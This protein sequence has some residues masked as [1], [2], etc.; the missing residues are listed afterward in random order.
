MNT[1]TIANAAAEQ[2]INNGRAARTEIKGFPAAAGPIHGWIVSWEL[3]GGKVPYPA[4]VAA[5]RS[6]GLDPT[7]AR[8]MLP[9]NA[10]KRAARTLAEARIIRPLGGDGA[11]MRFQFTAESRGVDQINYAL[12]TIMSLDLE[13]GAITSDRD[14]L[15]EAAT[16]A[17]EEAVATRTTSDITAIIQR[18]FSDKKK[19]TLD[20][21]PINRRGVYFCR[22]EEAAFLDRIEAFCGNLGGQLM[23]LP[24]AAGTEGGD[25]QVKVATA[26]RM[27]DLIEDLEESTEAFGAET[28]ER[29]MTNA[30]ERVKLIRFKIA[31]YQT[32]LDD[33]KGRLDLALKAATERLKAKILE[34]G[35]MR[36]AAASEIS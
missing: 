5:L 34:V 15:T 30:A 27:A 23:R 1:A 16:L 8:A 32:Y 21:I 12:E 22:K 13:S 28:T 10:F 24:I 25:K 9:Q 7:A 35:R 14:D 20:L 18:L 3:S 26:N 6:A 36:E 33:E 17:F 4:L 31:S 29:A 19:A 11:V 2:V